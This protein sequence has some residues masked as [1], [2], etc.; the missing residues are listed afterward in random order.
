M[1]A[2]RT[3]HCGVVR[4]LIPLPSQS[5]VQKPVLCLTQKTL[6]GPDMKRW[7]QILVLWVFWVLTLWLMAPCL[8][9]KPASEPQEKVTYLVPWCC[10]CLWFGFRKCGCPSATLNYSLCHHT[11]REQNWF[12]ACY[13]KMMGYLMGAMGSMTPD[14]VLW[15]LVSG[16]HW[17]QSSSL[18]F[19][20]LAHFLLS[21]PNPCPCPWLSASST[22]TTSAP[23]RHMEVSPTQVCFPSIGSCYLGPSTQSIPFGCF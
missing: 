10:N 23:D 15:W 8:D 1:E 20:S 5:Q 7:W 13:K 6:P 14:A 11:V 16:Q 3:E 21:G 22:F 17:A 12:D 9:Q 18:S 4:G 2:S 19:H